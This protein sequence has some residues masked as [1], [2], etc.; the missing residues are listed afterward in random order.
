MPRSLRDDHHH[1]RLERVGL[2]PVVGHD[3]ERRGAVDDLHDLVAVRV[4][5]PGSFAGKFGGVDGAVA[6]GRQPREG[7][8]AV[9]FRGLRGAS[10][11]HLELGE[12]GV[13]IK[14]GEHISLRS[15]MLPVC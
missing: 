4:P 10:A 7:A 12:L 13:E 2:P 8:L 9:G 6:V 3:V 14:D 11:Q 1:P 15:A 5:F